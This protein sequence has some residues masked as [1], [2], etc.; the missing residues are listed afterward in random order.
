[1]S[2]GNVLRIVASAMISMTPMSLAA[3]D[4]WTRKTDMPTARF[5]VSA[6]V[7][8]GRV[9]AI[10]GGVYRGGMVPNV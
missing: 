1:M 4:G 5:G 3:E 9:Y 10:G 7:V 6:S 2:S 8:D